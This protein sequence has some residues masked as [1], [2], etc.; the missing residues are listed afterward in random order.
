[1]SLASPRLHRGF[2]AV[3][4]CFQT[5]QR[6]TEKRGGLT[7]RPRQWHQ[8]SVHISCKYQKSTPCGLGGMRLHA[9]DRLQDLLG[10]GGRV[11]RWV[12]AVISHAR[13][14]VPNREEHRERQQQ[15]WLADRL[16]AQDS[17]LV[18]GVLEQ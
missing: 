16:G 5:S 8:H 9:L 17:V 11:E 4:P 7:R 13:H 3:S 12:D 18:V 2:L 15:R 6:S 1:M 14:S 10:R